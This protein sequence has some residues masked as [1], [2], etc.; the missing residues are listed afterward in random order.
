[1][2]H[3]RRQEGQELTHDCVETTC[4]HSL[5]HRHSCCMHPQARDV[6]RQVLTAHIFSKS[7][8]RWKHLF[9]E[10]KTLTPRVCKQNECTA[11]CRKYAHILLMRVR[12]GGYIVNLL[13]FY[14]YRLIGKL[15]AFSQL[16]EFS[17]RNLPVED[18]FTF[19]TRFSLLG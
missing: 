8:N 18:S 13:D 5:L 12:V 17:Q 2:R 7:K 14:S 3:C 19:A 10:K 6:L 1:M 4:T 15:T 16:Q 11:A 9:F